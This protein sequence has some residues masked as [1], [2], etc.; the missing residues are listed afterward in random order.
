MTLDSEKFVS[1]EFVALKS[2]PLNVSITGTG[3]G[4]IDRSINSPS[5]FADTEITLTALAEEGSIFNGW[6]GDVEMMDETITVTMKDAYSINAEFVALES[7]VLDVTATGTGRGRIYRN[8]DLPSYY[9]DTKV[10][11]TALAEGGSIFNGWHG[12]VNM[13]DDAIIVTMRSAYSIG[14]EFVQ[15]DIA[16]TEI[17]AELISIS[18]QEIKRDHYGIVFKLKLRNIGDQQVRIK[19]PLTRYVSK[20][21]QT[22]EQSAWTAGLVNGSK[23]VTLSAGTYCEMGLVHFVEKPLKGDR[24]FVHVEQ[25]KPSA[26]MSFTFQCT[27]DDGATYRPTFN[28]LLINASE[29]RL[30]EATV[31][32]APPAELARALK[33][34]ESLESTLAEVLC[35]LD[36]IQQSLPMG[37]RNSPSTQTC[38]AQ[39]LPEVLAWLAKH[40]QISVAELRARL[41]PLDLLPGA[42]IDELNERALD[43]TGELALEEVDD[44]ILVTRETLLEVL[45]NEEAGPT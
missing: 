10:T 22:S 35:R 7:F 29:D 40:E 6:H 42:V 34:I 25:V 33:R 16:D 27:G 28:F 1:A 14:A 21:G 3:R 24:L 30:G 45:A 44:L 18:R 39:T 17:T 23:G 32:K 26:R 4:L 5:Y 37:G 38:P 15:L 8:I 9:A 19:V 36:A 11:L 13:M 43:L 41:L 31:L 12:D 2:Y 20:N